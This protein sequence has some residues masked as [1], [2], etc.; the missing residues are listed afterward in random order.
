MEAIKAFALQVA[1]ARAAKAAA[2][3]EEARTGASQ[4]QLS[5]SASSPV[6]AQHQQTRHQRAQKLV[7]ATAALAHTRS[8]VNDST[9][10]LKTFARVE[11]A[12]KGFKSLHHI[13]EDSSAIAA[14]QDDS[15]AQ[16]KSGGREGG[17]EDME[18]D[19]E[20]RY[21]AFLL[22]NMRAEQHTQAR[23]VRRG[24]A[25]EFVRETFAAHQNSLGFARPLKRFGIKLNVRLMHHQHDAKTSSNHVTQRLVVMEDSI[26]LESLDDW[27]RTCLG[28]PRKQG[29]NLAWALASRS[30]TGMSIL[31]LRFLFYALDGRATVLDSKT[32]LHSWLDDM[33]AIHPPTL[34]V[35]ESDRQLEHAQ[36]REGSIRSVFDE[37]DGRQ[38]RV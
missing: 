23:L 22:R 6:H 19:L 33:W 8:N 15:A 37:Y 35:F 31:R 20:T 9:K 16:A 30:G 4:R 13:G 29:E 24:I 38:H 32:A 10:A 7:P 36:N 27:V 17:V 18:G 5:R 34:H 26:H 3:E 28:L 14:A 21:R 25:A 1:E 12:A 2:D 11:K